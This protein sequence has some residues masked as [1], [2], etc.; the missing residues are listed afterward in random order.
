MTKKPGEAIEMCLDML[1]NF[2]LQ[3]QPQLNIARAEL[4]DFLELLEAARE[5]R[6]FSGVSNRLRSALSRFDKEQA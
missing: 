4:A 5:A 1:L 2:T 6:D 3:L